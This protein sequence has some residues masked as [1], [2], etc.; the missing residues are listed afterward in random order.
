[1]KYKIIKLKA[2][3]SIDGYS[4]YKT[5]NDKAQTKALK[6]IEDKRRD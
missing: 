1:M 6:K 5:R 4:K 3:H 2:V